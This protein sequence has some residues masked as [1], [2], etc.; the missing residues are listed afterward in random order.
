VSA[1]LF[2]PGVICE[3]N[4]DVIAPETNKIRLRMRIV[5]YWLD[6][7]PLGGFLKQEI[8]IAI[9]KRRVSLIEFD[10]RHDPVAPLRRPIK[11][12]IVSLKQT[13]ALQ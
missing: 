4:R 3:L 12:K 9:L 10:E 8:S 13:I 7:P 1:G 5:D 11:A 6:K 2:L